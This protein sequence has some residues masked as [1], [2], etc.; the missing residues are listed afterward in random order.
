MDKPRIRDIRAIRVRYKKQLILL[1]GFLLKG[2]AL[3]SSALH[4]LL[5]HLRQVHPLRY[6]PD[7]A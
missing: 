2:G 1:H 3:V 4:A 5:V 6:P 7:S